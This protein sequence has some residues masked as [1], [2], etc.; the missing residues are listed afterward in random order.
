[1][2]IEGGARVGYVNP[3]EKTFEYLNGRPYS[4]NEPAW[5]SAVS[6]WKLIASDLGCSYDDV[7]L[8][9]TH[10]KYLQP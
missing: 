6:A 10:Q 8:I 7:L 3:D 9:L 5:D 4:P 2:S 1:M